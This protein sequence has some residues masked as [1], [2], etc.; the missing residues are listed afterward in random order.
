MHLRHADRILSSLGKDTGAARATICRLAARRWTAVQPLREAS[1]KAR[2]DG[3]R[4]SR[5]GAQQLRGGNGPS[6]L[7]EQVAR[8]GTLRRRFGILD[9]RR[10]ER[11]IRNV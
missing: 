2:G 10:A 5:V 4:R 6:V 8:L 3:T 7:S 1:A 9:A 11:G